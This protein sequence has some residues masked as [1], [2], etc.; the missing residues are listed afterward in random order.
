MHTSLSPD[1]I[2]L[3]PPTLKSLTLVG[4]SYDSVLGSGVVVS[5]LPLQPLS[6]RAFN[7][8]FGPLLQHRDHGPNPLSVYDG[9]S[10][11]TTVRVPYIVVFPVNN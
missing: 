3:E 9:P 4:P 5:S 8:P 6:Y 10:S 2:G 11:L 1:W 7:P